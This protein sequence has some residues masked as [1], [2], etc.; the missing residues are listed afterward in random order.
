MP[1]NKETDAKQDMGKEYKNALIWLAYVEGRGL[2]KQ[3]ERMIATGVQ[4]KG[5]RVDQIPPQ[6][7][8]PDDE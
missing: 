4:A 2:R 8:E 7:T 6:K 3:I 1:F 5:K